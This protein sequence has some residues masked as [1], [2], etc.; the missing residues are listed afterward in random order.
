MGVGVNEME[1]WSLDDWYK[2]Q[3]KV[4]REEMK[5]DDKTSVGTSSKNK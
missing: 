1:N 2:W 4:I 3:R 5:A